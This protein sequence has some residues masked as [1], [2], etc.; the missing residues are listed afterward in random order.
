[1][2][3]PEEI[4]EEPEST[5]TIRNLIIEEMPRHEDGSS[6]GVAMIINC[7]KAFCNFYHFSLGDLSVAI[8]TPVKMLIGELEELQKTDL[9]S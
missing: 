1:M 5:N 8:V 9:V 3:E 7:L 6:T 4:S 2:T